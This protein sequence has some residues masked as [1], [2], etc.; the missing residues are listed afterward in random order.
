MFTITNKKFSA[1]ILAMTGAL[2]LTIL[3]PSASAEENYNGDTRLAGYLYS[4][5]LTN[6]NYG[7]EEKYDYNGDTRLAGYLYSRGLT[8]NDYGNEEKH[9]YNGDTRLAGYL[10]SRGLC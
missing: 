5:G 7:N 4:R 10:Y 1:R 3:A 9:D 2:L 8:N 6:N